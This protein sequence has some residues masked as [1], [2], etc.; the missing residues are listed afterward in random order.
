M[1]TA[2]A[3]ALGVA[4]FMGFVALAEGVDMQLAIFAGMGRAIIVCGLIILVC[5]TIA[6][7]FENSEAYFLLSKDISREKFVFAYWLAFNVI[8]LILVF[9]MTLAFFIIGKP[10]ASGVFLWSLSFLCEIMITTMFALLCSL[11]MRNLV[12][13][14]F[15]SFGFYLLS[16]ILGLFYAA[17]LTLSYSAFYNFFLVITNFLVRFLP[18]IAPRFDLFTQSGWIRYGGDIGL[19]KLIILQTIIYATI[20]FAMAFHDIRKKQF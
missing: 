5:S 14:L 10:N 4:T 6:K 12:I 9:S 7:S 1:A 8:S 11:M 16:R 15:S 17:E 18:N 13:S 3:I 20:M 19:L 2:V